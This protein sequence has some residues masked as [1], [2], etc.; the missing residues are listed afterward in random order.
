MPRSDSNIPPFGTLIA[1]LALTFG[2]LGV[3]MGAPA[4]EPI[5]AELVDNAVVRASAVDAFAGGSSLPSSVRFE[6]PWT[7]GEPAG[8]VAVV[9]RGEQP[10][11]HALFAEG[12]Q[13]DEWTRWD[14]IE[15]PRDA[16]A[17]TERFLFGDN[18]GQAEV[19]VGEGESAR[20]CGSWL[21]GRW[22]CGPHPWLYVGEGEIQVRGRPQRC[23]WAHPSDEGPLQILFR[24]VPLGDIVSGRHMLADVGVRNG[25]PG[26]V[27]FRVFVDDEL[28]GERTQ[29]QRQ[30]LNTFRFSI[31]DAA[32]RGDVRFEV[33]AEV[34]A[35]RHFCFTAQTRPSPS[36]GRPGFDPREGRT[37]RPERVDL[38][39]SGDSTESEGEIEEAGSGDGV[40]ELAGSGDSVLQPAEGSE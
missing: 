36:I 9:T 20:A 33:S 27:T 2:V 21:F 8:A 1:A 10:R 40:P 22:Q 14:L 12:A 25:V 29:P 13:T 39:G 4:N 37:H 23:I 38:A 26:D 3:V 17:S 19:S 7:R 30:G 28:L 15:P 31:S 5:P 24:D 34:T 16:V 18:L 11:P 6:P 35:Q 32:E